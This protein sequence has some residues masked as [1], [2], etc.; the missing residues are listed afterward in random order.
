MIKD[1]DIAFTNKIKAWYSNTIYA[2]TA[3][4]YN[5]A[6]NLVEDDPF[7]GALRFPLISIYRPT[8]FTLQPGQTFAARRRGIPIKIDDINHETTNARFLVVGLPYQ[9]DIYAKTPETLDDI[10]EQI[11]FSLNLDQKMEVIQHDK[12]SETDYKESY[13]IV[14]GDGPSELSEFT[15]GDRIYHYSLLY[16]IDG[17]RIVNFSGTPDVEVIDGL[18]TSVIVDG[19]DQ[20][21]L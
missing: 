19:H 3:I 16:N 9:I 17:A 14:H 1:F 8:G 4:V 5:V 21:E 11:M 2:N 13:D 6:Y 10:T 12:N 15:D 18:D 7:E 20:G